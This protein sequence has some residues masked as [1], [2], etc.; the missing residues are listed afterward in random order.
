MQRLRKAMTAGQLEA[1][2]WH[3]GEGDSGAGRAPLYEDRL[4]DLIRR[5]REAAG[6]DELPFIVGQLGQFKE[7]SEGRHIVNA[8]HENVAA[9]VTNT[10]FVSS[11]GLTDKGDGTH[12]DAASARELGHRYAEA[13][14]DIQQATTQ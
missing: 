1:I 10:S 13:Y 8:A 9:R 12:F 2:L 14:A 7:W 11:D 6:N 3:Q 5:F 4:H